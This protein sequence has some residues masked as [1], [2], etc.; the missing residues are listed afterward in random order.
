MYV[1]AGKEVALQQKMVGATLSAFMHDFVGWTKIAGISR[2]SHVSLIGR[3]MRRPCK[4]SGNLMT[5]NQ[6]RR[7]QLGKVGRSPVIH[8]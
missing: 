8:Y 1:D 7:D 4:L 5:M 2:C 6:L 3:Q